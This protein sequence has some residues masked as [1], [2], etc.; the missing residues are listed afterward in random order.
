MG[1]QHLGEQGKHMGEQGQHLG[2]QGEHMGSAGRASGVGRVSIWAGQSVHL[3][4][5]GCAYG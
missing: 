3:G 5:A 4:K 1:K 2:E